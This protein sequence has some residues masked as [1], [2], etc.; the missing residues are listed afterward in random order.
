[1]LDRD[2]FAIPRPVTPAEII[3]LQN[4]GFQRNHK[5][6]EC[7]KPIAMSGHLDIRYETIKY[8][9]YFIVNLKRSNSK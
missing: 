9:Q 5:Q 8:S 6:V 3:F 7:L 2:F 4:L 1:M